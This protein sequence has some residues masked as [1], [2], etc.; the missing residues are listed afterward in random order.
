MNTD[1]FRVV[2][3][4]SWDVGGQFKES[5]NQ[6]CSGCQGHLEVIKKTAENKMT[7]VMVLINK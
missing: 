4:G 1:G 7:H 3:D 2:C 6:V 5:V